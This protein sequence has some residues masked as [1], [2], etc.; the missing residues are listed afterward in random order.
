MNAG[1]F[2]LNYLKQI[3]ENIISVPQRN[4]PRKVPYPLILIGGKCNC[5]L[6]QIIISFVIIVFKSSITFWLR[7]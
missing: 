2:S 6:A 4:I 5:N 3:N 7:A 1:E